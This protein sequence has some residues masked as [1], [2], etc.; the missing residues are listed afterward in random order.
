[1]SA[2]NTRSLPDSRLKVLE[3]FVVVLVLFLTGRLWQLQVV[4]GDHYA[5]LA[6]GNR[7]RLI[8]TPAPRGTIYDRNGQPLASNRMAFIISVVPMDMKNPDEVIPL[9]ADIIGMDADEI[10]EK[11]K[12]KTTGKYRRPFE[13]VRLVVDASPELVAK[14]EERRFELPGVMV[15]EIPVRYYPNGSLAAHVLGYIGEISKEELAVLGEKG[16][17]GGDIVGKVGI[18]KVLEDKLRG[19]AGGQ[20]VEVNSAY[21]PTRILGSKEP[22]PGADVVLTID[23]KVQAAAEKALADQIAAIREKGEYP[24]VSGGSVVAISPKTGEILAMASYPTFNPGDFVG[25]LSP[26]TWAYLSSSARP[27]TNRAVSGEYAPGSTFKAIVAI[28]ALAEGKVTP[29]EKFV[30]SRSASSKYY[31]KKC[32]VWSQ[33]RTHGVLDLAGGLANSC[34][35][36]FYELGRRLGPDLI[37]KYARMFGLGSPTGLQFYPAERRGLVPDP[38]FKASRFTGYNKTW[39]EAETLDYAIGQGFLTVTPLQMANVY[40]TIASRGHIHQPTLIKRIEGP[41]EEGE[42]EPEHKETGF[43]KLDDQVWDEVIKGLTQVV[44]RGTAA[45]AFWGFPIPTAGKSGSAQPPKGDTNGWFAAFA[46]V[47]DPQIVVL[48]MVEHGGGGSSAAAPIVR[49]VLEAYFGIQKP[50]AAAKP[51]PDEAG[52]FGAEAGGAAAGLSEAASADD[53][54]TAQVHDRSVQE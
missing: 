9:L 35:I 1:M 12:E 33:G 50:G 28:A 44:T 32:W 49:K 27:L 25:G 38:A 26:E 19:V 2:G 4:Q 8:S 20:Q 11:I 29:D 45:G 41:G 46:P 21:R 36:V 5:A 39:Y 3:V 16:Y 13:P 34:N 47:D 48:A 6:D 53:L 37:A 24:D 31:G 43:I 23:A 51:G 18:E 42:W 22:I 15:E 52:T 14:I 40:A 10:R 17:R 7:I 30:C 54:G